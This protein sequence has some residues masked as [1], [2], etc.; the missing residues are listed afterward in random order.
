M[1]KSLRRRRR[2]IIAASV[3]LVAAPLT[4]L[5]AR[6]TTLGS[7]QNPDGKRLVAQPQDAG[8]PRGGARLDKTWL[9]VPLGV[10]ALVMLI[11]IGL[12]ISLWIRYRR[13]EAAYSRDRK[14]LGDQAP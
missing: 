10:M 4:F 8:T 11:P 3:I 9:L 2:L 14:A 12:G 7:R 1:L 13:A 6:H 5:G